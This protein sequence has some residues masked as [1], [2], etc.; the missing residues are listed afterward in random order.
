M[1]LPVNCHGNADRLTKASGRETTAALFPFDP[2]VSR[3]SK[4]LISQPP[5]LIDR[6]SSISSLQK[7]GGKL[8]IGRKCNCVSG[9]AYVLPNCEWIQVS[10][11][12]S[13][14]Q[15][16]ASRGVVAVEFADS[17]ALQQL[18]SVSLSC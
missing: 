10:T 11:G 4:T 5:L 15:V 14:P 6:F 2:S 16:S 17:A 9:A 1:P 8:V 13:S 3:R 18:P 12:E 7:V